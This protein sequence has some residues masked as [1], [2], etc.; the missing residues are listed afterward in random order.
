MLP[1]L[2][3]S[4]LYMIASNSYEVK[5]LPLRLMKDWTA[6]LLIFDSPH[7]FSV[8]HK[9]HE[10][11]SY[12]AIN[13]DLWSCTLLS[14][15]TSVFKSLNRT[16]SAS[17]GKNYDPKILLSTSFLSYELLWDS[18]AS[19]NSFISILPSP[20][21]SSSLSSDLASSQDNQSPWL[22]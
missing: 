6:P 15:S 21:L 8:F 13:L 22:L 18:N 5:Y 3:V 19:L 1:S 4:T 7:T 9:S 20:F 14:S 2:S 11:A 17:S 12:L 10:W 16:L